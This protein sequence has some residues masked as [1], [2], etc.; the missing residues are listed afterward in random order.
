MSLPEGL[1]DTG[2]AVIGATGGSG[3]RVVARILRRAGLFIGTELNQMEDAFRLGGYSDRWINVSLFHRDRPLPPDVKRAMLGDLGDVLR[4]HCSGLVSKQAWGWKEPRSIYL[5]EFFHTHLPAFRFLHVV[6]DGRDMA[7]AVNQRQLEK[8]GEAAGIPTDLPPGVRSISLWS[9]MNLAAADFGE[10]RL[11]DRYRRIR[12]EDLCACPVEVA[13]E[14]I[15]FLELD[16]DAAVVLDE[17]VPPDSLGRWR[18][19]DPRTIAEL[20][21]VASE[22]LVELGYEL[23]G[24]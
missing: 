12:F 20:E 6:R 7:L 13:A 8:H 10:T 4:E 19:E 5:L 21:R 14:I 16:G 17:V 22:A 11:G 1:L 23:S 3:T 15:G 18:N 9:Q 2:P 24:R